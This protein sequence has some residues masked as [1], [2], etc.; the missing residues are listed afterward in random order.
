MLYVRLEKEKGIRVRVRLGGRS[1]VVNGNH[2]S[3]AA[4]G[5]DCARTEAA[6]DRAPGTRPPAPLPPARRYASPSEDLSLH[7]FDVVKPIADIALD[8]SGLVAA[9]GRESPTVIT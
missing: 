9:T 1:G 5:R 4:G 7:A 8:I 6:R 2:E 3:L